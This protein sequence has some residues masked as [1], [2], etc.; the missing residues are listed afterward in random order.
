[1]AEWTDNAAAVIYDYLRL[2]RGI[3]FDEI[4]NASFKAAHPICEAQVPNTRPDDRYLDWDETSKRYA[5]NGVIFA[6]DDPEQMMD[7][8]RFVIRGHIFEHNTRFH[9]VVGQNR[10]PTTVIWDGDI[11]EGS[12]VA[13]PSLSD[14]INVGNMEIEQSKYHD[15]QNYSAPAI[16]DDG[17]R[18]SVMASGSRRILV[19]AFW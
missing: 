7:E 18:L 11:L 10:N 14:R 16:V 15:F 12:I 13:A 2:R 4:D 6:D 3:P 1:M 17:S 9:I 5:I 8:F 19:A